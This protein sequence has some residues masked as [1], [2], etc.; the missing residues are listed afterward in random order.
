MFKGKRVFVSGGAGVIGRELVAMLHRAGAELLVGDLKPRPADW[1]ADIRYWQGDLNGMPAAEFRQF[2]PHIFFHLAATFE[3][4]TETYE[5]W[6]ENDRHNTRLSH[7]L[8]DVL[9]HVPEL[10]RV[11]F[12]SS[13]LI[14]NPDLYQFDQPAAA[15]VRLKETD[16]VYPRNLCGMA[17]LA[18]EMEL[19][20]LAEHA[21]GR[22]SAVSARIYRV[23]GKDSRDVI[24]RWIR[25]LLR[26]ETIRVY[27]REGMF[28]Y[29]YAGDVAE[30]LFRLAQTDKSGIVNLGNGRARRVSEVLEVLS[31]HFPDMKMVDEESDIPYEASEADMS[32]F[33]AWTG[34]RPRRQ[35]EDVIPEL[36]GHYRQAGIGREADPATEAAKTGISAPGVQTPAAES[37]TPA[38]AVL[39]SSVS[40]K[41]PLVRCVRE[42]IGKLG[43]RMEIIGADADAACIGQHFTDRFWHMP[44]L[45]RLSVDELASYCE[46]N[47]V[48]HIIP[49]RDGELLWY[50][51]A[52]EALA[53][54]G[55][56]VL[57]SPPETVAVCIDKLEFYRF[58]EREG[59]PVIPTEESLERLNADSCVVKERFGAGARKMALN[60]SREEA[61]RHAA[62]LEEPIF[63][64]YIRGMEVSADLYVDRSG[65]CKGVVLRRREVVIGGESQVTT[66]YRDEKLERLCGAFAEK[67]GIYGHAIMQIMVDDAGG[68]HFIECNARLGGASRLS[69][70]AGLDSL[71]WFMLESEGADPDDVPF[72]RAPREMRLIRYAEDVIG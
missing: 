54:K 31:R 55:V 43:R 45:D 3:R 17:K 21:G 24:S 13:Y 49:T 27:R 56:S 12:A 18:H 32:R 57:V 67:L 70:A 39:I 51:R 30:G 50:A 68:Y 7:Y 4:S 60:V 22:F 63:Q 40:R 9:R 46:A 69:L 6:E 26:G 10:E 59:F 35:I 66:T 47:R 71:Y 61:A 28:D 14:Y 36:I 72:R 53:E 20:F 23:Y 25:A 34:W 64:P 42:A 15:P 62:R 2:A 38:P 29:I 37:G 33:E 16:P 48:R 11:V 8:M 1:P 41:V 65:R 19:R 52:R 5:F 44:R 58:G